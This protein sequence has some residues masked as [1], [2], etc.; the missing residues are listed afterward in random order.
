MEEERHTALKSRLLAARAGCF[1]GAHALAVV[2]S[3]A[4]HCWWCRVDMDRKIGCWKIELG[5]RRVDVV[6]I[7]ARWM[8]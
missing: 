8:I 6:V 7:V 5:E 4:G 2:A 1:L 3:A